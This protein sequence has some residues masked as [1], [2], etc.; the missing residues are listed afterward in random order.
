MRV[1]TVRG[2]ERIL[3]PPRSRPGKMYQLRGFGIARTA[4]GWAER[5]DHFVR[6]AAMESG[7]L[8]QSGPERTVS[9]PERQRAAHPERELPAGRRPVAGGS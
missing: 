1:F 2:P 4:G 6:L 3:I 7:P 8:T 5:G 9:D